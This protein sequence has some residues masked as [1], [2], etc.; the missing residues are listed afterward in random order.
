V[1]FLEKHMYL[2]SVIHS[3]VKS[4]RGTYSI[5]SRLL[6][7]LSYYILVVSANYG[8]WFGGKYCIWAQLWFGGKQRG[9]VLIRGYE[10][11]LCNVIELGPYSQNFLSSRICLSKTYVNLKEV[12]YLQKNL[13]IYLSFCLSLNVSKTYRKIEYVK[14]DNIFHFYISYH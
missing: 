11:R 14:Y 1:A 12:W 2:L 13:R 10:S 6:L 5:D 3:I 4:T 8:I 9:L 7:W